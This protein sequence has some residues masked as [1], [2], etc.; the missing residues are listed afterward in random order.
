MANFGNK[1]LF[2]KLDLE[3]FFEKFETEAKSVS[4][5][6]TIVAA[7]AGRLLEGECGYEDASQFSDAVLVDVASVCFEDV[8]KNLPRV[9]SGTDT[10]NVYARI[11]SL[12][13][14]LSEV[15][16]SSGDEKVDRAQKLLT[17][18]H[19]HNY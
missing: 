10:E 4:L 13:Y 3:E 12:R 11:F 19:T 18:L 2:S 1:D 16:E 5:K 8:L 6:E 14:L 9:L 7:I 17:L 15:K